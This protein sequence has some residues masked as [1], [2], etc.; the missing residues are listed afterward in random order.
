MSKRLSWPGPMLETIE[1]LPWYRFAR[2]NLPA[3][4]PVNVFV[5]TWLA[6][7]ENV[8]CVRAEDYS[9]LLK[10]YQEL[11]K[12]TVSTVDSKQ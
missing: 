3:N 6:I 2:P 9:R 1:Q 11:V 4:A 5:E 8:T 12:K 10:A 7:R